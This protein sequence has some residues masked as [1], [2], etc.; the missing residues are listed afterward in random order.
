MHDSAN[1]TSYIA[2]FFETETQAFRGLDALRDLRDKGEIAL[3]A[4]AVIRRDE[5]AG[6]YVSK[7]RNEPGIRATFGLALGFLAGMAPEASKQ[8]GRHLAPGRAA[9]VAE[10]REGAAMPIDRAMAALGGQAYRRPG[11][12]MR[13]EFFELDDAG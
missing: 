11:D 5:T 13:H 6:L 4:A 2:V 8:A 1:D 12:G 10:V 9:V 7:N 3:H